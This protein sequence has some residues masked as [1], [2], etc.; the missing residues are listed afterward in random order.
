MMILPAWAGETVTIYSP[1]PPGYTLDPALFEVIATANKQQDQ[2][3]F[4]MERRPGGNTLLS[5]RAMEMRK[6]S[7]LSLIGAPTVELFRQSVLTDSDYVPVIA[8]GD[9]CWAVVSKVNQGSVA[10]LKQVPNAQ[11]TWGTGGIGGASHLTGLQISSAIGKT[12]NFVHFKS[13]ADANTVL[14]G[15]NN[16]NLSLMSVRAFKTFNAKNPSIKMI[17]M[18]CDRR[19]PQAAEVRTLKEQGISAP[20]VFN[21]IV[22]HREF[23]A[24]KLQTIASILNQAASAVGNERIMELTDFNSPQ[25]NTQSA[26]NFHRRKLHEINDYL[27][28]YSEQIKKETLQ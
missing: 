5:I 27:D 14:V 7:S 22:A 16:L 1:Y 2:F 8:F 19:H 21:T 4:V 15:D 26:V 12:I 11:L 6:N 9:A 10:G 28:R 20:A 18:S 17:A 25:F 13:A 3:V 23:D 24:V